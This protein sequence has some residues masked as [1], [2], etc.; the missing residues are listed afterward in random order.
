MKLALPSSGKEMDTLIDS[1]FGRCRYFMVIDSDTLSFE[2][3]ENPFQSAA[4]GVGIQA[5]Q[6]M[7]EQGVKIILAARV[8][9][10]ALK[11]LKA[12]GLTVI[13]GIQG[14]IREAIETYRAGEP[15]NPA[16]TSEASENP[17][18]SEKEARP[19]LGSG[20]KCI[21]L[22][23]GTSIEHRRG[24]PCKEEICPKCK[25]RMRRE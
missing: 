10:N 7:A 18:P 11:V 21:C 5:A 24:V 12:A 25:A 15:V 13:T 8:G 2:I 6:W 20:G 14:K 3:R 16:T 22:K 4:G 19:G 1:R 17:I 23:C 9:P